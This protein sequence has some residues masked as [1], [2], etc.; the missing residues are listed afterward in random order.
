[1]S[2]IN[3]YKCMIC[4]TEEISS[5]VML[6]CA[7][8]GSDEI[9]KLEIVPNIDIV[10]PKK[11]YSRPYYKPNKNKISIS[12]IDSIVS[13]DDKKSYDDLLKTIVTISDFD[14]SKTDIE[15]KSATKLEIISKFVK[16]NWKTITR[17]AL[18]GILGVIL[19]NI[20]KVI[21]M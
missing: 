5:S 20:A 21:Y 9:S 17:V 8:C 7:A 15:S 10:K 6:N 14:K 16:R 2:T 12:S 1:M 11:S 13:D 19:Y 4:G 3:R 18:P